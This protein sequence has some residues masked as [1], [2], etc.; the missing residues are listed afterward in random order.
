MP[1]QYKFKDA[2]IAGKYD[3]EARWKPIVSFGAIIT[4]FIMYRFV[5]LGHL[6]GRASQERDRHP[7]SAGSQR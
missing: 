7:K 6:I 3:Q 4:I 1:Y 2:E 5:R